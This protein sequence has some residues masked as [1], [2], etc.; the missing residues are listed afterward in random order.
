M[1]HDARGQRPGH[2][3]GPVF[4]KKHVLIFSLV[5]LALVFIGVIGG[6]IHGSDSDREQFPTPAPASPTPRPSSQTAPGP[7][8]GPYLVGDPWQPRVRA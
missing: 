4:K 2:E 5:P 1:S 7:D 3:R 6:S 8:A